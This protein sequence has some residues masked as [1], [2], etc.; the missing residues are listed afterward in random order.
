MHCHQLFICNRWNTRTILKGKKWVSFINSKAEKNKSGRKQETIVEGTR[1]NLRNR[2]RRGS[3]Y[4]RWIGSVIVIQSQLR[5]RDL[6]SFFTMKK[7]TAH[8]YIVVVCCLPSHLPVYHYIFTVIAYT[9]K[10]TH[11]KPRIFKS[12]EGGE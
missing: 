8:H 4:Y 11:N 5:S 2:D 6:L 1:C 9:Y 12:T 10:Y 3:V 7:E